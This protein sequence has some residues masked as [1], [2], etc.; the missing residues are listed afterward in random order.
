MIHALPVVVVSYNTRDLLRSCLESLAL[1]TLPTQA[2]VVDNGSHDGSIEMVRTHFPETQLLETGAN[3][4]FA[5]ANNLALEQILAS[6]ARYV[7]LLN[8][9]AALT[10]GALEQLVAFGE[11]HPRVGM[12]APRLVY[13]D[14]SF[15]AAAF[16]FPGLLMAFFDLYPPRGPGLGRLYQHALNGR[17]VQ[18]GGNTP[19]P[20]DHP[21][22]AAML[23]RTATI[24]EVGLFDPT[25]WLY[26]EEVEWC[27]RMRKAGWAIW[28]EPRATII[29]AA[30]ASSQQF[31][32]RSFLA[33]HHA[34]QQLF[35]RMH[36]P[37]WNRAY[38]GL[39][40]LG[41][42]TRT[43]GAL[44]ERLQGRIDNAELRRRTWAWHMIHRR[45]WQPPWA[46]HEQ[47]STEH[48]HG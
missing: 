25:F 17:Y 28:Q 4:G 32:V 38:R 6:A 10:A 23:V 24:R 46:F 3:I 13:P 27:W 45:N 41:T 22:G 30:G 5:R 44:R 39:L 34:R 15:Q 33:L 42:L 47:S 43:L 35:Q 29:H 7:L 19:F 16:R 2:W 9:D 20:I 48:F 26:A 8:P 21:L 11:A 40:M 31:K 12:V 18:D 37:R 14:G 36:S 1:S